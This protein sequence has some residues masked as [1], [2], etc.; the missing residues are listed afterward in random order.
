MRKHKFIK[1]L[2]QQSLISL[3]EP[4]LSIT[5]NFEPYETTTFSL[6]TTNISTL[7]D[8]AL[9]EGYCVQIGDLLVLDYD[10]NTNEVLIC[11]QWENIEYVV[12]RVLEHYQFTKA[13]MEI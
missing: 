11:G 8:N 6:T 3:A 9:S 1:Q 7:I 5:T 13:L 2:D 12:E 10:P 4:E